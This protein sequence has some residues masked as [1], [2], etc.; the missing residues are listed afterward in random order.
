M[1]FVVVAKRRSFFRNNVITF[2]TEKTKIIQDDPRNKKRLSAMNR[3]GSDSNA[4]DSFTKSIKYRNGVELDQQRTKVKDLIQK[5]H[6]QR[7]VAETLGI[8]QG[9]VTRALKYLQK[10]SQESKQIDEPIEHQPR[11]GGHQDQ[12]ILI[13]QRDGDSN[14]EQSVPFE[15]YIGNFASFDCEWFR[16]DVKENSSNGRADQIYCFCLIDVYGETEQIHI[17][18]F[19]G[20]RNAFMNAILDVMER[21]PLLIGYW[22]FGDNKKILADLDHIKINCIGNVQEVSFWTYT[23]YSAIGQFK[24]P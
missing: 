12:Q 18:Q 20:D 16:S 22:I 14:P 13:Q 8:S 4:P 3:V 17:N 23:K 5:G 24:D 15:N 9:A 11:P 10:H 7:K 1:S 2:E 21:Y 6:T 19:N